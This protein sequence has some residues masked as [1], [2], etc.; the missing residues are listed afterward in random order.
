MDIEGQD[1][2]PARKRRESARRATD[3]N[4]AESG[5]L[6]S[7]F[8]VDVYSLGV[9]VRKSVACAIATLVDRCLAFWPVINVLKRVGP[10]NEFVDLVLVLL[11]FFADDVGREPT[12]RLRFGRSDEF[13][14]ERVR[15][16]LRLRFSDDELRRG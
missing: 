2:P 15:S 10:T 13:D 7:G 12:L 16:L 11:L 5:S 9:T 8:A 1:L 3:G 6:G 14:R 4:T